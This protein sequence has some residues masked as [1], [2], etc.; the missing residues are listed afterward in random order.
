MYRKYSALISDSQEDPF[1]SLS[2]FIRNGTEQYSWAHF[3]ESTKPDIT[4][5]K[6]KQKLPNV[7][8]TKELSHEEVIKASICDQKDCANYMT[9]VIVFVYLVY[10]FDFA[11]LVFSSRSSGTL[12]MVDF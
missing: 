6:K 12:S 9:F 4:V 7:E 11:G 1:F 8:P 3:S 10:V 2:A 5:L